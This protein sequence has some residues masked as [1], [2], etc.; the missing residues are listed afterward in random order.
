MNLKKFGI[1]I[2]TKNFDAS[3]KFYQKFGLVPIFVYGPE[4]FL[5]KFNGVHHAKEEYRGITF[6]LGAALLELGEDHIA[7][8]KEV[9]QEK[10]A[11]S[12][13]SAMIDVA[14][15]DTVREIC[16]ANEFEIAKEEV[17]Y[18]WGT[19]ELVVRDPDGFILVFREFIHATTTY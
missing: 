4:S 1:H 16:L 14:N 3:L 11:S 15:L 7:I 9:F 5:N 17:E 8:K 6:E 18:P 2:K 13:V 10:I 12:K 19:K